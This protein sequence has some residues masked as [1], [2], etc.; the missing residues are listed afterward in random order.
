MGLFGVI[1][2][3]YLTYLELF[4]IKAVCIW[5]LSSAMLIALVLLLAVGPAAAV[6][7]GDGEE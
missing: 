4:I 7:A 6:L 3:I 1:F 5:C 2:S